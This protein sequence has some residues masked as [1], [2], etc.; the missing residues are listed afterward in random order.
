VT[1]ETID[2]DRIIIVDGDT[3]A[4]PCE[5]PAQGC[6]EKI[7]FVD[8]DAPESFQPHCDAGLDAGLKRKH[9]STT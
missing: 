3:V 6:A 9:E 5:V 4:L 8:I 1:A 2:G 7:R